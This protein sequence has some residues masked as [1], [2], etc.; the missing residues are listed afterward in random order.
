MA[1]NF[2]NRYTYLSKRTKEIFE[3]SAIT[4][5][6]R[7]IARYYPFSPVLE[8]VGNL[9]YSIT[10]VTLAAIEVLQFRLSRGTIDFPRSI[11]I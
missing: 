8:V 9:T 4:F 7:K 3:Y 10:L 5:S 2:I 6:V 11:H 1:S